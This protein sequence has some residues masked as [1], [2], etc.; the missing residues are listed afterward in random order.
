MRAM[1]GAWLGSC[2]VSLVLVSS[3]CGTPRAEC[4]TAF[5]R[6]DVFVEGSPWDVAI[7]RIDGDS[8]ADY[9]V[10]ELHSR[11]IAL[12]RGVIDGSPT[13]LGSAPSPAGPIAI[14]GGDFNND[15]CSDFV[16]MNAYQPVL[17]V[18]F[19]ACNASFV[20]LGCVDFTRCGY[21]NR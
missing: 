3:F 18:F 2:T 7:G 8:I 4:S 19:G 12:F 1:S 9:A 21:C 11:A 14:K 10:A 13:P 20:R 15:G 5:T 17:S 6:T 16:V